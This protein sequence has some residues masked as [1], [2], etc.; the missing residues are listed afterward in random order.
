MA[1]S[2]VKL[3]SQ[4]IKNMIF[5]LRLIGNKFVNQKSENRIYK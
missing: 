3:F 4:P 2:F 1:V 5:N